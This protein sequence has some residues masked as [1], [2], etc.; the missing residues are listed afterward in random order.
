MM[1]DILPSLESQEAVKEKYHFPQWAAITVMN[2]QHVI[3]A[4][5]KKVIFS[6]EMLRAKLP[7]N[8]AFGGTFKFYFNV[9]K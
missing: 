8:G 9:I 3:S 5:K 4:S 6:D 7:E 2:T 1:K